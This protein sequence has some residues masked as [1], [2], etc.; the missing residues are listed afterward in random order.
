MGPYS[1]AFLTFMGGIKNLCLPISRPNIYFQ[2]P[3]SK[4]ATVSVLEGVSEDMSGR[5]FEPDLLSSAPGS[6]SGSA[7]ASG[8]SAASNS[9]T[10]AGW[11]QDF[12]K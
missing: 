7:S 3:A 1:M 10:S 9:A 8:R 4:A 11:T 6:R 12:S 2:L 5:A